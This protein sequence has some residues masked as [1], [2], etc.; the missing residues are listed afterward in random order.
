M[1]AC[2]HAALTHEPHRRAARKLRVPAQNDPFPH[3]RPR[4]NCELSQP[5]PPGKNERS[6]RDKSFCVL[7]MYDSLASQ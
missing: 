6:K 4:G 1:S 3:K 2:S 5:K 7:R